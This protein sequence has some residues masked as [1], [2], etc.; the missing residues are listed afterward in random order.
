MKKYTYHII[1]IDVIED[2]Y[3]D[4]ELD[5][6]SIYINQPTE[7]FNSITDLLSDLD[8]C[9]KNVIYYSDD[10]IYEACELISEDGL[11]PSELE[12]TKWKR[13][14]IKLFNQYNL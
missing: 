13:G 12:I 14:E 3:N 11:P 5:R 4:G 2:S 1:S 8:T 6:D 9:A 10:N 7:L